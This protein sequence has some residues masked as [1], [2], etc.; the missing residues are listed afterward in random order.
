[1]VASFIAPLA[2]PP[3]KA[4]KEAKAIMKPIRRPM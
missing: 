4:L 3:D 2:G 1:M